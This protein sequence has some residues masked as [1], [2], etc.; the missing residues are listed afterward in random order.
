VVLPGDGDGIELKPWRSAQSAVVGSSIAF[1][2][3]VA[4]ALARTFPQAPVIVR[5]GGMSVLEPVLCPAIVV[6]SAPAARSG[7]ESMSMR[8]YT[9]YEYTQTVARAIEEFVRKSRT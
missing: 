3:A 9:T 1:A 8:G 5:T 7:P 6:E 2:Q 4:D